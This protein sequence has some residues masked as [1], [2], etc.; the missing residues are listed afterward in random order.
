M[1]LI[2]A[3]TG[4][5]PLLQTR[6][7]YIPVQGMQVRMIPRVDIHEAG[8]LGQKGSVALQE[9]SLLCVC[10]YERPGRLGRTGMCV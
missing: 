4:R 7:V 8:C 9:W 3:A 6:P 1:M 5:S 2:R 10:L